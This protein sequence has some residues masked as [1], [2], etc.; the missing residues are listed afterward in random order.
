MTL[1]TRTTNKDVATY[2]YA[3][4]KRVTDQ[5]TL[6][7]IVSLRIPP[8]WIEVKIWY[9]VSQPQTCCGR[10]AKGRLQCLYSATHKTRAKKE[11]YCQLIG[12]GESLPRVQADISKALESDRW[13]RNKVIALVLRL[14]MC[15]GFRLGT[16]AYEAQND[17]FGI[18]TIRREH[19]RAVADG[20][21]IHFVGKKGVENDCNVTDPALVRL[22]RDLLAVKKA[23]PHVMMYTLGGEWIHLRHTEVND[24][25]RERGNTFTSK[26]FRTW[27]ANMTLIDLLRAEDPNGLS[28]AARKRAVNVA[29]D[30]VSDAIHNTRAVT[31]S[32]YCDPEVIEMYIDHP[33]K[34][35]KMFITPGTPAR[36]MFINFLKLKCVTG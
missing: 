26:M 33:V 2:T 25:L 19:I 14:V 27:H 30:Q 6:D 32:Q 35:R 8:A 18:T 28:V 16:A 21:N 9:G 12:F 1:I 3:D 17:S 10:D 36:N 13:T 24:W 11:K 5:A 34:Y 7:W 23:D 22:L 29:A 4:G 15:C 31:K 20:L